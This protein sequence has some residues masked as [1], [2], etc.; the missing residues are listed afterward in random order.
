MEAFKTKNIVAGYNWLLPVR[1]RL[2]PEM[3]SS[4]AGCAVTGFV[5]WPATL[6]STHP[7]PHL[8]T[9]GS[10]ASIGSRLGKGEW[11]GKTPTK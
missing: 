6:V 8:G 1:L 3:R 2:V 5:I 11:E 10:V 4:S 9:G 7:H